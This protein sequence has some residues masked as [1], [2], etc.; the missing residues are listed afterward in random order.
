VYLLKYLIVS[1]FCLTALLYADE[2]VIEFDNV[3]ELLQWYSQ[4]SSIENKVDE[5][6]DLVIIKINN[7]QKNDKEQKV[8]STNEII[9]DK[10]ID[11][12]ELLPDATVIEDVDTHAKTS[13]ENI[14]EITNENLN[15]NYLPLATIVEDHN[16]TEIVSDSIQY[17]DQN[18][19]K[20]IT[21]VKYADD[22]TESTC[23][24]AVKNKIDFWELLD[25]AMTKSTELILKKHDI[26]ITKKNMDIVKS[27]YYPNLS[28]GYSG[29]Y[30]HGFGSGDASIS[31]SYYPSYS[32]YRDSINLNVKHELYRFGA[33]DLKMEMSKK[34]IEIIK[35]ELALAEEDVSKKLLTYYIQAVKSQ[36]NMQFKDDMRLV[37]D[38]ILQ[39]KWRLYEV[40]QVGKTII[41]R[42]KLS[43]VSLE[44]DILNHE[45]NYIDA[46]KM[47]QLLTNLELDP[48][49]V[50]FTIPTPKNSEAKIFEES[51]IAKNL[52]LNLEKKLQELELIKKDY[53]PTIYANSGYRFYG[54]DDDSFTKTIKNLEKNSWDVGVSLRWD[55]FSGFKTD[56]SVERAKLEI[57]KLV[58]QYRLAKVDFESQQAK[59]ESLKLAIDKILRVESEILD[60]TCQQEELLTK[61]ESAGEVSS[62]ELDNIELNKLRS[63]LNF[64]LGVIDQVQATISNE[65][66]K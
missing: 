25:I 43:L 46:V 30:Y 24:S 47:I 57:Q 16:N 19:S 42:D 13:N 17:L 35:S 41:L 8:L 58:E 55:L 11:P 45:M 62:I 27:E 12:I 49:S 4:K 2:D 14:R 61:L 34:D 56:S 66:I 6:D 20:P 10:P 3:Q 50:K 52:K 48:K 39:K 53:K 51:A 26:Q 18:E 33:T 63:K 36:I 7:D 29:E 37:Q 40:G 9:N 15:M 54:A 60:Q 21:I 23:A 22:A 28:L 64:R 31:G 59:R 44:K 1:L 65:L 32:Q 38:R 5:E